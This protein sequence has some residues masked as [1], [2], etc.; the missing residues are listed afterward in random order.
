MPHQHRHTRKAKQPK[1]TAKLNFNGD[2]ERLEIHRE[3]ALLRIAGGARPGKKKRRLLKERIRKLDEVQKR[4]GTY[5][6]PQK[7]ER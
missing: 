1:R 4:N 3:L 2:L 5:R 7:E 6:N